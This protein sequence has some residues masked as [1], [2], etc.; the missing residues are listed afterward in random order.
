MVI[1][2]KFG[3]TSVA[4]GRN[5]EKVI[6]IILSNPARRVN[7]MSAPGKRYSQDTKVTDMLIQ[8]GQ[9]T[10]RGLGQPEYMEDIYRRFI[11]ITDHFEIESSFLVGL[12]ESLDEAKN[13]V[14]S[15]REEYLDGIKPY[16]E[17][18]ISEI[19]AGVLRKRGVDAQVYRP[20]DIG[21]RTDGNF[22]N[23]KLKETSY[24][25]IA[26]SLNPALEGSNRVIIVPGFYGID[27]HGR[28]MT[29]QRGGSDLSG[30]ILA[31]ALDADLY[32]NWTDSNGIKRAHPD[33]VENPETIER[34]TYREARELAYLGAEILHPDTLKPLIDK[35]IPLSVR[36]TFD[37]DQN[38]TYITATKEANGYV[39]EGIAHNDRITAMYVEKTGMDEIVGY[40]E[41]LS[42]IFT[43]H[44]V[45][46]NQFTAAVDS[47]SLTFAEG[48]NEQIESI[49]DR[50]VREGLVDNI[51]GIRVEYDR[52][53]VC[54]VGEGMSHTPGIL[55]RLSTALASEGINI[56][57]VSQASEI[58][59]IFGLKT[60]DAKNAVKVLHNLYF[61]KSN[62]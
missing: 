46:I 61:P 30:A 36:N 45:S 59:I 43:E 44:G 2:T 51:N 40:I 55:G 6:D 1:V 52:S 60:I 14:L 11:D 41:R 62:M 24:A 13:N 28:Y 26:A 15:D 56:E 5:L 4:N 7:V 48:Y 10:V 37:P 21:M 33:V 31:N 23:A 32:E 35:N 16:G 3:G 27:E 12:F 29:F 53:V 19:I 39:V 57:T 50:M 47:I 20:E 34:L 8:M 38:G 22:G 18:I 25:E 54:V 58:S 49:N 9:E 17:I 42:S